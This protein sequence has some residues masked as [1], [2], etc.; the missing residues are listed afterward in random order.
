M[1]TNQIALVKKSWR[2]FKGINPEV[3]S[4]L[5]YTKLFTD[6]P[7]LRK[8][9]PKNMQVQYQKLFDMLQALVMNLD[10]LDTMLEDLKAMA[11]RHVGYG[12]KESHY[13]L[14]GDALLWTLAKGL[15]NDWT[16][17]LENAWV[18]CYTEI[19]ACM[20]EAAYS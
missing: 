11:K 17:E 20:V 16:E 12:V 14:V 10:K 8:M 18:T 7:G 6:N 3:V 2:A 4:D 5:F 1:T 19:T 9:F 13:K 15:S